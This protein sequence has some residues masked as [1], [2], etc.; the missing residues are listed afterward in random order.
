M[1]FVYTKL[2][3]SLPSLSWLAVMGTD[4]TVE[5]IHGKSVCCTPDFFVSGVWDGRFEDGD[6]DTCNFSCCT[7]AR[8]T[9]NNITFSTPHHV[10]AC[11]YLVEDKGKLYF[12]NSAAFLLA[13]TDFCYD[14]DYYNYDKDFCS[15]FLG[16][17]SN[18]KSTP[19]NRG[20]MYIFTFCNITVDKNLHYTSVP[21]KSD[22]DF[23]SF[24]D[25]R[26]SLTS[27][28]KRL[29]ANGTSPS[30]GG[31]NSSYGMIATISKG[32][33]APTCC[34]VAKECGCNEV[35]TFNRPVHYAGDC[36]SDIAAVLGFE[37]IYELDADDYKRNEEFLEALNVS[38]GDTGS[39]IVIDAQHKYFGNKLLFCGCR[40]DAIW[41]IRKRQNN[42]LVFESETSSEN[43]YELFLRTNTVL[44]MPP[45]IG[46]DHASQ[47]YDIALSDELAD[48]RLGTLYDRPICRKIVEDA[49]VEREKFGLKKVG[50]GFC[51]HFDN[52]WTVKHKMSPK[53]YESLLAYSKKLKQNKFKKFKYLSKFYFKNFPVYASYILK[54]FKIN[55]N[56]DMPKEHMSNPFST[57]YILWGMDIAIKEYKKALKK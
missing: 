41:G 6:F 35:F 10:Q 18:M 51:Y 43:S 20:V 22:Y 44:V 7:G 31:G 5:I 53:S 29:V 19:L 24:A 13:Y 30:R 2:G 1:K 46:A 23:R 16:N 47:L 21:R 14:A 8:I 32:Y 40:G 9:D 28:I 34:V 54:K 17:E 42:H 15:E 36:G 12:S 26:E 25:Y 56:W 11:I 52:I 57:T 39:M 49:G 55:V 37:N 3:D 27:T 38:S 4:G 48:Y 50:A 33:D 45:Y